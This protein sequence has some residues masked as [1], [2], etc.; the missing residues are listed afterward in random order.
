VVT[1]TAHRDQ[2]RER[3]G[4]VVADQLVSCHQL[5]P[6]GLEPSRQPF[7]QVGAPLVG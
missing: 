7:M 4:E 2:V 5:R 1:V 6:A 3:L